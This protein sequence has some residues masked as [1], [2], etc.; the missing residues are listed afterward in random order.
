MKRYQFFGNALLSLFVWAFGAIALSAQEAAPASG[1]PAHMV[2]TVEA[3]H[4]SEVPIIHREDVMVYEGKNRDTVTDWVPA[5]GDHAAL[6]LVLLLDDESGTNLGS[7]LDDLKKFIEGQ[8]ESTKVAVAYMQ[9][10]T[11]RMAQNLTADHAQA[12]KALRLPLGVAGINASPYFSVSDLVKRWPETSA[13]REVVMVSDGI[14]RYY[15]TGDLSDPYVDAAISDAQR[16]GIIVSAIYSPGVGHFAH[17]R[18]QSYWGQMYLAQ[19][20]EKTGGEAYY[21][22]MT[23]GPV[24]FAP[25]LD[26]VANRLKHQYLLTFL[27]KPPKKA[28]LQRVKIRTE[29]SNVDLVS[30][31]QVFVPA[32]AK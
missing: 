16:A 24:A 20:A 9:D 12:A 5:E 13:R 19:L 1:A 18:W 3:H 10:G 17:S 23:G 21:I 6:E 11:A 27:A 30:A 14:D 29:V 15:G 31:E 32:A 2:V 4:G 26:D 8:P 7:Q 22:G 25:Y 28:G